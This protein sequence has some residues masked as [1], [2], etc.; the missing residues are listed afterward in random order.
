MRAHNEYRAG[1]W[2]EARVIMLDE[3][4][5]G[6]EYAIVEFLDVFFVHRSTV[7]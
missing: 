6:V 1:A 5:T 2:S 4:T 3:A 7:S